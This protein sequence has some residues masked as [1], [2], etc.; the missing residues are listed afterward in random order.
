MAKQLKV[1]VVGASIAGPSTAYWLAK[2]GALV[3]VIERFPHLRPGGQNIDIRTSGVKVMRKIPGMEE[4][5]KS[6]LVHID[7]LSFVRSDGRPY[8]VLGKSGDPDQQSLLSEY[9]IF[10]DELSKI[11]YDMTK[12]DENVEYV[13]NEQ[14]TSIQ[15][16][17]F[18]SPIAVEFMNGH[19]PD[20]FDL[21]VACDG[22]TSRT[23]ALALECG[24]RDYVH[25]MHI[26]A[27]Y[28]SIHSD[29]LKTNI[30]TAHGAV[31]GR[32]VTLGPDSP[33]RNRAGFFRSYPKSDTAHQAAFYEA[34]RSQE[35]LKD[36]VAKDFGH[37]GWRVPEILEAVKD[38]KDFY[39]SEV[40]QV[41][42]P[43]LSKGRFVMVGDAGYAPG[44]TGAGTTLAM[45]GAYVLGGEIAKHPGDLA[46]GLAG[47]EKTMRPLITEMQ[48]IPPGVTSILCPQSAWGLWLRN[49]IFMFVTWTGIVDFMQRHFSA[50]TSSSDKFPLAEY[51]WVR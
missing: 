25:P 34:N 46:A 37:M 15:Q 18:D 48:K 35:A 2:A 7:G 4:K 9:E 24:V 16:S 20:K 19:P 33:N 17:D 14:V 44:F 49:H 8:G 23:R 21:V 1:L 26:W 51:E 41:R 40:V 43:A 12:D 6:R 22:A 3:T 11:M 47:Y 27:A 45:T 13:F 39:A 42:L 32:S 50:A 28:S 36:F 31:G 10:R 5:V 38:S 30:G 29:M